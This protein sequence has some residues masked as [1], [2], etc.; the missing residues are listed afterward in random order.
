M[1]LT[2]TDIAKAS[3]DIILL[4]DDFSSITVA[5][6]YGRNVYDNVRKFIQF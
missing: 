4:D 1:N 2:G 3:S 5:L 6:L